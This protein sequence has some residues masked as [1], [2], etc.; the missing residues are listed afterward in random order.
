MLLQNL[1]WRHGEFVELMTT[2]A[3]SGS[4]VSS[5]SHDGEPVQE[6]VGY[7]LAE[8]VK[9]PQERHSRSVMPWQSHS[10]SLLP[11]LCNL[12]RS[13]WRESS[14]KSCWSSMTAS[15][16]SQLLHPTSWDVSQTETENGLWAGYVCMQKHRFG[17]VHAEVQLRLQNRAGAVNY[18]IPLENI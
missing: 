11:T 3:F 15:D 6:P 17:F 14:Q 12:L 5:P 4:V 10:S 18:Y 8:G 2:T 9:D 13:P 16:C 7:H 1:F